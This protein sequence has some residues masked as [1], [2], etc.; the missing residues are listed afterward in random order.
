MADERGYSPVT[1][2]T[3]LQHVDQAERFIRS[4]FGRRLV[5]SQPEHMRAFLATLPSAVTRNGYLC[6]L[7]SYFR[8]ARE[9][10]YR[11]TDPMA[12][13][14]RARTPRYLPRPLPMAHAY[15]LRS[16]A[17]SLSLRHRVIVD[18][19]LYAGPR[20]AE[21]AHLR[22]DDVDLE[23]RRIRFMGKT[24][25]GV[26]PLHE[27]LVPLLQTWRMAVW[28]SEWVFPSNRGGPMR[29]ASIWRF[30]KEAG[31]AAGVR[32]T[33]HMLRHSFA[34]ELLEAGSDVRRVQ[35]LLRHASL[36]STQ[37]YTKVSVGRLE[38]DVARLDFGG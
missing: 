33:T 29:P 5:M 35:E 31:A 37:I 11:R 14:A 32:V 15:R 16:A 12:E 21:I 36:A 30:V 34:T 27:C 22:W 9:R 28:P 3:R 7:R 10:R 26:V 18:L 20:R 6:D 24:G 25:E 8:F 38:E 4:T 1:R 13:I 17:T 23:A 2:R 19:A